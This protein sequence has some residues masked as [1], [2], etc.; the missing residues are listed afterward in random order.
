MACL[1]VKHLHQVQ[2][3]NMGEAEA[4]TSVEQEIASPEVQEHV[5]DKVEQSVQ[6]ESNSQ[7]KNWRAL[8][9]KERY[10]EDQI[11]KQQE[12]IEKLMFQNQPVAAK[13]EDPED[14]DD[15]Y[16]PHGKV[17]KV[18][19]K[20]MAPIEEK[21][22]KLE[23]QLENE[24]RFQ[25]FN[26]LK[27][28]FPDFE[29]VVNNDTLS[30]L[31]QED[32]ELAQTIADLK[33]PYKIAIQSYKYIKASGLASKVPQARRVREVEQKLEKNS[34]TVQSPMAYDKR[35]MAQAFRMTDQLQAELLKE[36]TDCAARAGFSY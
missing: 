20:Q 23:E 30:L 35:P 26:S 24:K 6:E 11:K 4:E 34:K 31:E 13:I 2:R 1:V 33:D 19:Q 8:R 5:E 32:P 16:I 7:D 15:E 29:D 28:K 9:Q 18:A 10:L 17:K 27:V 12:M 36:M 21:L 22:R 14:P 3:E 25:Q